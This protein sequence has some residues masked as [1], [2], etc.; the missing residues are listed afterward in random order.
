MIN[1]I[2]EISNPILRSIAAGIFLGSLVTIPAALV[3]QLVKS[4]KDSNL[5]SNSKLAVYASLASTVIGAAI[6]LG[7]GKR[8]IVTISDEM[9]LVWTL[10]VEERGDYWRSFTRKNC[11]AFYKKC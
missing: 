10:Q 8:K 2:R 6:G 5:E 3:V 7:A 4:P 1:N 11:N 9:L